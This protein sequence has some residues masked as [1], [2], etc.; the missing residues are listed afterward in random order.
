PGAHVG[1]WRPEGPVFLS[2]PF[3]W[4]SNVR[5]FTMTSTDQ[6]RTEGPDSLTSAAYAADFNE[7]RTMGSATGSG[8]HT[9]Q[10]TGAPVYSL[11]PLLM[12]S[13]AFREVAAA[14][15]LSNTEAARLFGMT[16]LSSA[17]A[18]IGCWD[19]KDFWSFWRPIHAIREAA[20]DGNA[21]TA[22]QDGW[23]PL[24]VTPPYP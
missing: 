11:N 2:D 14:N 17:D 24:L 5:P 9:D 13:K 19:N 18:L 21:A 12:E 1:E 7:V 16:S 15:G 4:V 3:A 20:A 22:P 23:L 8:G 6:F 10:T